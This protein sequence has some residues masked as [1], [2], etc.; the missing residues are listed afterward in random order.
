MYDL[1]I[2]YKEV[3]ALEPAVAAWGYLWRNRK[4]YVHCDNQAAVAII[5]KGTCRNDLVMDSL[6]RIYW[7]SA[8]GNFRLKAVYHPDI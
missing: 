8:I 6:R 2:N 7:A 4:V 1:H 5:N 3:M